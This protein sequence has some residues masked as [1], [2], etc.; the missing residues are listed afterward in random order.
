MSYRIKTA[1]RLTGIPRNT[2]LAWERRYQVVE[3]ARASNGYRLYSDADISRLISVRQMLDQGF[4][5]GEAV[6]L[7]REAREESADSSTPAGV[8]VTVVHPGLVEQLRAAGV[9]PEALVVSRSVGTL[10]ELTASEPTPTDV[11][12]VRLELLG[13]QPRRTLR[14]H[15]QR[16]GGPMVIVPYSFAPQHVLRGL[17]AAGIRIVREPVRAAQ[18]VSIVHEVV[19]LTR[20]SVDLA[21]GMRGPPPAVSVPAT[22]HAPVPRRFDDLDLARFAEIQSS[23]A[24]EC[25]N[26]LADITRALVAFETYASHCASENPED[27]ALHA[28]LERNT[29]RARHVVEEMLWEVAVRDDLP[30]GAAAA[31][32]AGDTPT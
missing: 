17:I 5:V 32:A 15:Q 18:L 16:L 31:Q 9:G 27:E 30:V 12:I 6:R 2:L 14:S 13:D 20:T 26:H 4:K 22:D 8:R 1:A 7:L 11:L 21:V 29:S 24:C 3:P 25:P 19:A 28:W 10:A 23:I